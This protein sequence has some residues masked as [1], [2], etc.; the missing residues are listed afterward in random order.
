MTAP[1]PESTTQPIDVTQA[2]ESV[3]SGEALANLQEL[4]MTTG[5]ELGKNVLV[6]LLIFFIG[7]SI[8]GALVKGIRT[9]M[10][11]NEVDATLVSFITNLL[12]MT[13]MVVVFIAVIGQL[14]IETTSFLTVL[15]AAGLA[16]G[17]ALQGS[18]SNFAAGVL[19]VLFRP[20]KVG[21]FIEAAGTSGIVEGLQILVTVMRT[22][23][24][25]KI[26]VPNSQ[27][28]SSIITN[29]SANDTRRVDFTVGVSYSDDIDEVRAALQS[30][31]DADERI[32]KDKDIAIVVTEL[33]DSSVN[34]TVR[35]WVETG[36]YWPVM[37]DLIENTKKRFDEKGISIPFPQQDVYMHQVPAS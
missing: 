35:V 12:R 3:M 26:I 19:I 5:V 37:L 23:D 15:G 17:L 20:Y 27:I 32:M 31:V 34:F 9:V 16:V 6:A 28:M 30:L 33:A 2:V 10:E 24:N 1:T 8:V 7:R 11:K 4:A 29:Y 18:L 13:L 22:P 36:N 25:K 21:D 14:G